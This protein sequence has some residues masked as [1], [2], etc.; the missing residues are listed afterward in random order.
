M[1][2]DTMASALFSMRKSETGIYA[3]PCIHYR[4]CTSQSFPVARLLQTT[5]KTLEKK[6][7]DPYLAHSSSLHTPV[8]L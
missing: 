5:G 1:H 7:P 8:P 6:A 3:V 4:Q 2:Q